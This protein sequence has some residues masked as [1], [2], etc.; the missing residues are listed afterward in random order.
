MLFVRPISSD[1][2]P[3]FRLFQ[4]CVLCRPAPR[5]ARSG[6]TL[7]SLEK[8]VGQIFNSSFFLTTF[9]VCSWYESPKPTQVLPIPPSR[10]RQL[11][12]VEVGPNEPPRKRCPELAALHV[13]DTSQQWRKRKSSI[14]TESSPGR[15]SIRTP[16][17]TRTRKL[18]PVLLLPIHEPQELLFTTHLSIRLRLNLRKLQALQTYNIFSNGP[19]RTP[20]ARTAGMFV[21]CLSY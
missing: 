4:T 20:R 1:Y 15:V 21:F 18:D 13:P 17:K 16:T 10:S 12:D 2:V 8:A 3:R 7:K 6:I 14:S 9:Q 19:R 11:L 5:F